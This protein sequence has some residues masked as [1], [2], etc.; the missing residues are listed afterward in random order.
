MAAPTVPVVLATVLAQDPLGLCLTHEAHPPVTGHDA[1]RHEDFAQRPGMFCGPTASVIAVDV[2]ASASRIHTRA[3]PY[4]RRVPHDGEVPGAPSAQIPFTLGWNVTISVG[5][6]DSTFMVAHRSAALR[7]GGRWHVSANEGAEPGD[8]PVSGTV[9]TAM[10]AARALREELGL[11]VDLD[12][13]TPVT[14]AHTLF[15]V[16]GDVSLGVGIH[17]RLGQLGVTAGDVR[18]AHAGAVDAWE[19]DALAE[20]GASSG[21]LR[22]FAPPERWTP[23]AGVCFAGAVAVLGRAALVP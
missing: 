3:M 1:Q 13:L 2:A 21:A 17:V 6:G 20:V 15:T 19:I 18:S 5:A 9:A 23:W 16:P 11:V 10:I 22:R 4:C 12:E 14:V 8:L 7:N